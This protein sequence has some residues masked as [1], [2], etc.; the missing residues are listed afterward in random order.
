MKAV[1][2]LQNH[3]IHGG[4]NNKKWQFLA[5]WL[6]KLRLSHR[7]SSQ[8]LQSRQARVTRASLVMVIEWLL[9][10][11]D[12][13]STI[14]CLVALGIQWWTQLH[15]ISSFLNDILNLASS[16][17]RRNPNWKG[18]HFFLLVFLLGAAASARSLASLASISALRSLSRSSFS[19]CSA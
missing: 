18:L 7:I 13:N 5:A 9:E 14:V 3:G 6:Y 1:V 4:K 12:P 2:Q 19:S 17:L 15:S 8:V 11:V 10:M 16:L